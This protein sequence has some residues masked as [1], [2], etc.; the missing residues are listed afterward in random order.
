MNARHLHTAGQIKRR[1]NARKRARHESF[2]ATRGT[3]QQHV[4]TAR[5]RNTQRALGG[6]LTAH[7]AEINRG[8]VTRHGNFFL[9][10]G[11]V[12]RTRQNRHRVRQR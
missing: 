2:S 5:R 12:L 11:R 8:N 9:Q 4:V 1:Q 10:R 6:L 3:N 7:A